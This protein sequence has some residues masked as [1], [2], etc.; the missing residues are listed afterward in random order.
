MKKAIL[1]SV[2]LSACIMISF[3]H[4]NL[5]SLPIGSSIP[6][7]DVEM[8][9]VSGKTISLAQARKD[10]GL[11]VMFSCNTCPVVIANQSRTKQ[12]C[13]YALDN[14]IG[15][16]VINSNE[17]GRNSGESFESMQA[18]ANQQSYQWFYVLDKNDVLADAFSASR[19]PEC[20]LFDK[21]NKL[22]YHGAI[23]DSPGK[24]SDVKHSYLKEAI[25]EMI[26]GKNITVKES[27]S[28]G[29]SINRG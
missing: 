28:I 6:K 25:D 4:E 26:T 13:K 1:F 14:K 21:N 8:K 20:F 15:V 3:K 23:D 17:G 19:T 16:T 18:Y 2:L 22:V 7:S 10:D 29:C 11:L 27:R 12:V 5:N 24:M 9:D